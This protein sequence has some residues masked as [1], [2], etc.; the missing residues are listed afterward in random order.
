MPKFNIGDK[1]VYHGEL[2][3]ITDVHQYMPTKTGRKKL[4]W[5]SVRLDGMRSQYAVAQKTNSL[6]KVKEA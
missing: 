5:Y 2:A 6:K 1:V 3:T 4:L